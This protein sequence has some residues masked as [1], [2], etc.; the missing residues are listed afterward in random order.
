MGKR[1][2]LAGQGESEGPWGHR[3]GPVMIWQVSQRIRLWGHILTL[4]EKPARPGD[5]EKE[6]DY[7]AFLISGMGDILFRTV[8]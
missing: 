6:A 4:H 7:F 5:D 3:V 1:V 2:I 8:K